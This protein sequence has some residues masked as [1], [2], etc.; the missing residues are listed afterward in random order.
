MKKVKLSLDA[1]TVE[2]FAVAT[3]PAEKGTVDA[4]QPSGKPFT[5]DTCQD[6]CQT[7]GACP[8]LVTNGMLSC[9]C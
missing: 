2:S 1:L 7:H 6:S 5:C 8:C 3:E 4:H 9:F